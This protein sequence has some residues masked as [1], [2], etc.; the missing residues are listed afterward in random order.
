VKVNY[1]QKQIK[2][3]HRVSSNLTLFLKFFIPV[4]WTV[5]FTAFTI[6]LYVAGENMLPFLTSDIFRIPFTIFYFIFLFLI[7]STIF[8]LKRVEMGTE[9]Y[10]VTN[11]FKTYRL[12]Y[13]D[14]DKISRIKLGRLSWTTFH[15]KAKGSFGKH[16]SFLQSNNLYKT[17]CN[18]HAT[19]CQKLEDLAN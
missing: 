17:F 3:M 4:G 5:F 15:L 14:I 7:Y 2:K 13:D 11:Y 1:Q 10:F 19:I 6:A 18:D 9:D 8:Q 16:I 12:I